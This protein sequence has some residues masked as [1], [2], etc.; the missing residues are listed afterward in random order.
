MG[1]VFTVVSLSFHYHN[2][3]L[4][5]QLSGSRQWSRILMGFVVLCWSHCLLFMVWQVCLFFVF[6]LGVVV[7]VLFFLLAC[8]MWVCCDDQ[9]FRVP[10][11]G[12]KIVDFREESNWGCVYNFLE[13]VNL[14]ILLKNQWKFTW[15]KKKRI[16]CMPFARM[17][18]SKLRFQYFS[19]GKTCYRLML[20]VSK[21]L[22][23]GLKGVI[24][25][26]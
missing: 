24:M 17:H 25:R 13:F 3:L 16:L 12:K 5:T 10:F 21:A 1:E 15:G 20:G 14:K 6:C 7:V 11:I 18:H 2:E 22:T 19:G 26:F 8:K 9:L 4:P 23:S